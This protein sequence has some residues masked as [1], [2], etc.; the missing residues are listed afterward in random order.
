MK[1]LLL[2]GLAFIVFS[3]MVVGIE[4]AAYLKS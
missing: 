3:V 2:R 4:G 1:R